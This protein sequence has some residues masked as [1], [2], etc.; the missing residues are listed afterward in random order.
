MHCA[1]CELV[2]ERKLRKTKGVSSAKASL[3]ERLVNVTG[4]DLDVEE[5]NNQ[6]QQTLYSTPQQPFRCAY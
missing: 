6:V 5:L 1:A 2:I 3:N 4:H